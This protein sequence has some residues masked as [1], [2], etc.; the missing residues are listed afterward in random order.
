MIPMKKRWSFHDDDNTI[1][2]LR[3]KRQQMSSLSP[4]LVD[5]HSAKGRVGPFQVLLLPLEA[6]RI[7]LGFGNISPVYLHLLLQSF[8]SIF[9]LMWLNW[10]AVHCSWIIEDKKKKTERK[11]E[12]EGETEAP[13]CETP[14]VSAFSSWKSSPQW[15]KERCPY[16]QM[17]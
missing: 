6:P 10:G 3:A 7:I 17:S 9:L 2:N 13:M 4:E 14:K 1:W 11:R 8:L 16:W 15:R 5:F 12:R